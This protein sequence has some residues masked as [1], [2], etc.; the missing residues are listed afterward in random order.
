MLSV[1]VDLF[2]FTDHTEL[3]TLFERRAFTDEDPDAP[4]EAVSAVVA[5]GA[6]TDPEDVE[7]EAV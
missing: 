1:P 5:G 2:P 3:V 7:A 6:G 4:V